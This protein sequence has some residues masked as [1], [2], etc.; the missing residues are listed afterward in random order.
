MFG[1]IRKHQTWLWAVIITLTIISFVV[2][3]SPYAKFNNNGA[4][5]SGNFG[6]IND[7]KVSRDDYASAL[8]EVEL[9]YFF[10]SGG[11]WPDAGAKQSGFDPERETY[12]WLLLAQKQDQMDIHSSSE[13]AAHTARQMIAQFQ[14]A[15]VTSP[16][17]FVE[18]V[19]VPHGFAME[20]LERFA[21]HFLGIQELI[22]TMGVSGKLVTPEEAK[23]LYV[24]EHE[25]LATAAVFFLASNYLASVT[26]PSPVALSQFYSNRLA[27]YRIPDRVQVSYVKYDLTNYQA[28]ADAEMAKMTNL[29]EKIDA[30]YQQ[31]GSNFLRQV[32]AQSLAEAKVKIRE[33]QHKGIELDAARKLAN[34]FAS[35]LFDLEPQR[36]ENLALLAKTNSPNALTVRVTAP[37]DQDGPRDLEVGSSFAKAAFS[38]SPDTTPFAGPIDGDDGVYVIALAKSLPSEIPPLEQIREQVIADY[39]YSAAAGLARQMGAGFYPKLTNGLAQKQTFSAIAT[40][41]KLKP[42]ELPPFSISTRTLPDEV[43]D[44][45]NLN[46]LKQLAFST[47]P[48]TASEFKPTAEGGVILYVRSRMPLDEAKVQAELPAFINYVRNQRQNEAFQEWFSREAQRAFRETPLNQPKQQPPS[49]SSRPAKS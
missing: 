10:M 9:R 41:A 47:P 11:H 6:F 13:E 3:F 36:A 32:K 12:Q 7:Q 46:Q 26:A 42:V 14:K 4:G 35:Q 21:R 39:K 43:D 45:L 15:G 2:F 22:A 31:D 30:A 8:R 17:M 34:V 27:N 19:L 28:Q 44:H 5:G 1:T 38:L 40:E 37:F 29:D 16:E 48:G 24:R 49:M 18:K 23:G 25:E 20:D 33:A